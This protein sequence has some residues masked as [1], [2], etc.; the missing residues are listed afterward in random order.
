MVARRTVAGLGAAALALALGALA[1]CGDPGAT[2]P[3]VEG[4]YPLASDIR[5][6]LW[7]ARVSALTPG[8]SVEPG[9]SWQ[10]TFEVEAD[11]RE[12]NPRHGRFT[13]LIVALHAQRRH[14]E[15]GHY[16]AGDRTVALTSRFSTT[17]MPLE[18]FDG[19]PS[20]RLLHDRGGSPFEAVARFDLPADQ[21]DLASVHRISGTLDAQLP[22]DAP[23]GYYEP[24]LL[25]Y[26]EVEGVEEPV[27]LENFGDNSN[28]P[29][30]QVL[31][32]VAVGD[33][34]T[35]RLPWT[36]FG[37]HP[38]RGQS[39]LLPLEEQGHVALA[40]RSGFPHDYVLPPGH[41]DLTPALPSL[42]PD[43]AMA[44]VDGGIEVF[45][46][47]NNHY[48]DLATVELSCRV[49]SPD[50]T[51]DLGTHRPFPDG[52]AEVG[53]DGTLRVD[54]TRTGRYGVELTGQLEDRFGRRFEGGGSYVVH[55][56][57]PLTFSTSVK[58]GTSFL[59]GDSYPPKVNLVPPVPASVEVE[60]EYLPDSDPARAIRWSTAGEASRFGHFSPTG[61]ESLVFDEPGEYVSRVTARY[62]DAGGQLW[63]EQQVSSGV[64]APREER[65]IL[66]HGTR[67]LP[68]NFKPGLDY[69]GGVQRF[70]GRPDISTPIMPF[71][72]APLPDVFA[73]YHVADTLFIPSNGFNESIVEPHLS[74]TVEDAAL[75]ARMLAAHRMATVLPPPLLQFNAGPWTYLED[76]LQVSADSA[77]WFPADEAHAD[78]LPIMPI[79]E[80]GWNAFAYPERASVEAYVY[81]GV[82]RPGFPV[83][84][85]TMQSEALGLYW[86][87]SPNRFGHHFNAGTNGD[88]PGDFYRIQAGAVL[89]DRET[90]RN[91]YD[92]YAS[93]IVVVPTDGEA[94]AILPPGERPLVT[95]PGREHWIMLGLDTHDALEVGEPIRLGG[96][97]F[98]AVEADVTWEVISP[99][100]QRAT[101][102]GRANRL[103]IVRADRALPADEPGLYR[104]GVQVAWEDLRGDVIGTPDGW[105]WISV[106]PPD[107]PPTL[108]AELPVVTWID[109]AADVE[110]P[111]RWPA[112]LSRVTVHWAALMPGRV[113][114]QGSIEPTGAGW[115]Y[116]FS[117]AQA[118]AQHP[119]YDVRNYASGAA[120]LAD[121]VVFQFHLEADGPDG[122]VHDSLRLALRGTALLHFRELRENGM[123]AHP[124]ATGAPARPTEEGQP[125]GY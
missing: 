81:L 111:L 9:G 102:T 18:R 119:N 103:G 29:D 6:Y 16:L 15:D 42:Y 105:F 113:M 86:L 101:V 11:L 120:E 53:P 85:A 59:V 30:E 13:G 23:A 12:Y 5:P 75:R 69:Y 73:P 1:T 72:P 84:T 94:T 61:I 52:E 98:P 118:G 80:A 39:G 77:A 34:A 70:E 100:G 112:E 63:M 115:T 51:D 87:A 56:A 24:R 31:P 33:P 74:L 2:A 90:G 83:M 93:S 60:V 37:E 21:G 4:E 109:P 36:L 96:M 38:Y 68:Y 97:V 76:V 66:L 22:A 17:G 107:N 65:T 45:P 57:W 47:G 41:Y 25:V 14:D 62:E 26:A 125:H 10:A 104:V 49:Q 122:P 123:P 48:L 95:E 27:L 106:V 44:P 114:D 108:A 99:S 32:L 7:N 20:L 110:V 3:V 78:E 43:R 121:T 50:G 116:R 19:W 28:T 35:P 91:H 92:A 54:M 89:L 40:A 8:L 88:L 67:T 55:V 46:P 82:V 124:P 58:P 79:G 71:K 64:I 117:P